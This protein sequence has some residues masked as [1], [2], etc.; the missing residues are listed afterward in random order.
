[1]VLEIGSS[2]EVLVNLVCFSNFLNRVEKGSITI[3]FKKKGFKE[4]QYKR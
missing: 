4:S 2:I 3:K 1:M